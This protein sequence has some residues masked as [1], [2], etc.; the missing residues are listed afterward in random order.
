[1]KLPLFPRRL[2]VQEKWWNRLAE[3][4]ILGGTGLALLLGILLTLEEDDKTAIII[5]PLV[6]YLVAVGLYHCVLYVGFGSHKAQAHTPPKAA[7][8]KT[9]PSESGKADKVAVHLKWCNVFFLGGILGL[10]L[11]AILNSDFVA[12]IAGLIFLGVVYCMIAIEILV[13]KSAW[14]YAAIGSLLLGGIIG[15]IAFFCAYADA[16]KMVKKAGYSVGIL[17]PKELNFLGKKQ[18][19]FTTKMD[20][21]K[22]QSAKA[23]STPI[24]TASK[25]KTSNQWFLTIDSIESAKKA[26]AQGYGVAYVI[27]VLT[28]GVALF[29]LATDQSIGGIDA[30][31]MLD[32]LLFAVIGLGMQFYSRTAAVAGLVLFILEKTFQFSEGQISGAGIG[33]AIVFLFG[34]INGVRGT[35]AY[36]NFQNSHHAAQA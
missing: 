33:I 30:W 22:K 2:E 21:P 10:I 27:A 4:F 35:F 24:V 5:F 25:K 8:V 26:V 16:I 7:L 13:W 28:A 34:L 11:A 12:G 18:E 20:I 31:A 32:A 6:V 15:I 29:A 14:K 1:M 36:Q 19:G 17:G 3:V 9:V 23:A